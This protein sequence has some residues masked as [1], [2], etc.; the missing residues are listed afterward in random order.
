MQ[1]IEP[2]FPEHLLNATPEEKLAYFEHKKL[3]HPHLTQAYKLA[4]DCIEFSGKG[5][6]VPII[7]PTGVGT[8]ELGRKL[9]RNFNGT[10][11]T[12]DEDGRVLPLVGAIGFEAP[13]AGDRID[14]DYWK[15]VMTEMLHRGGDVLIDR[16]AYVPPSQFM[17]THPI[18]HADPRQKGIDTLI[19][20]T[21]NMLEHRRT[22]VVLINHADRLFPEADAAG[23]NR[24][25]QILMDLAAQ[26]HA[27]FVLIGGYQLVRSSCAR[28]N[29]LRRQHTVHFRRYDRNDSAEYAHFRAVLVDLLA[30]MPTVQRLDKIS[31][32]WVMRLYVSTVGCIGSMKRVLLL[33]LQ[34]ALRTGEKMTED[35]ILQFVLHNVVALEIAKEARMG[36]HLLM[37]VTDAEVEQ[38]LNGPLDA[39]N[40]GAMTVAKQRQK[41]PAGGKAGFGRRRI[42]ERKSSRD[43]VG[44]CNGK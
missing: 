19:H 1:H 8:T 34:H 10:A 26:T 29:W 37:D 38:V 2:K 11:P 6:I 13:N 31:E 33:A 30:H 7:G 21:V 20:A 23:C 39:E 18:P 5:E 35:F 43:P 25:Q 42:G 12:L 15:R 3:G 32:T 16:K 9:Y 17:L 40:V 28:N 41:A 44:G 14:K 36:E 27:R 4:L 22:K 24:S